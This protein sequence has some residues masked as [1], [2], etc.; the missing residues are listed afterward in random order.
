M[1]QIK[2]TKI[3]ATLGP[4]TE[5]KEIIEKMILEGVDV[6]RINFS[7]SNYDEISNQVEIIRKINKKIGGNTSILGDLQGPKLRIGEVDKNTL[8]KEGENL[9]LSCKSPFS[10]DSKKI[11]VNYEN[12]AKDVKVGE[13]ILVDDGKIIFKVLES[14]NRTE[15]KVNTVQGGKLK[16]R[17]GINLPNTKTSLPALTKKDIKDAMFSIQ[18]QFDWIALSFVRHSND[19]NQLRDLVV[20]KSNHKIPIIAKI[21]KPEAVK[22]IN[23]IIACCD[24]IMVARG[25][26]GVEIPPAEVPLVQKEIVLKSKKA[27]IPVIIATQMMENMIDNLS[28]TRAEVNDVANSVMDGA[29]AVMLSAETSVGN[30]PVEVIKSMSSII[31]SVENSDLI[32]VPQKPP[33]IRNERFITKSICY[34]AAHLANDVK[35]KA[36][37]TLTNSGYTAF[38]IS[39]WRPKSHVLVFTSN[40]RILTQLNLLWG[41]KAFFYD[42]FEST[43][44][45]VEQINKIA[46]EKGYVEKGDLLINLSAMPISAKG[47][48]NTLRISTMKD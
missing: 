42:S 15:V 46:I 35:A 2:K 24:G 5:D 27:R 7:H 21:E 29:D 36:I 38:Q 25:D 26:L 43:D 16:S 48:V 32:I 45:T 40:K 14:D 20:E 3:I 1:N 19:L 10:G 12:F 30:Y 11:F 47:K 44:K 6:F 22:N 17:K 8:I 13:D 4:S 18:N 37:C 9:I 28:A 23:E 33:E 31:K 34:H 39:A 41:V